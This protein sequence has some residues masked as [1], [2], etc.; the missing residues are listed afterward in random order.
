MVKRPDRNAREQRQLRRDYEARQA[1]HAAQVRRR[2]RDNWIA[3]IATVLVCGAAIFGQLAYFSWGPGAPA[4][5]ASATPSPTD[6]ASSTDSSL[7]TVERDDS[8]TSPSVDLSTDPPT[9]T[10]PAASVA[11]PTQLVVQVLEAGTGAAVAD[12]QSVTIDYHGVNWTT[13][14]IF[15][16]SYIKGQPATFTLDE[17]IDGFKDALIGQSVGST[18]LAILPSDLAYGDD[19]GDPNTSGALVFVIHIISAQ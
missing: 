10:L 5:D 6:S 17:V 7:G 9:V 14:A 19:T 4:P 11:A 8:L 3:V 12:G 2:R 16:S 13:A 1:V 15:D 18:I